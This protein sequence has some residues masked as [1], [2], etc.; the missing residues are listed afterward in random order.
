MQEALS[1][2]M[3]A[4]DSL[5]QERLD[6]LTN[7]RGMRCDKSLDPALVDLVGDCR[8]RS[9]YCIGVCASHAAWSCSAAL[10]PAME[11]SPIEGVLQWRPAGFVDADY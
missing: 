8:C 11:C 5:F 1:W 3:K 7:V 2:K 4:C 6:C 10:S 9:A